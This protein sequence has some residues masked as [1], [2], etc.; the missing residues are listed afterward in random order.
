MGI[1]DELRGGGGKVNLFFHARNRPKRVKCVRCVVI[2]TWTC[3]GLDWSVGFKR[4]RKERGGKRWKEGRDENRE[5]AVETYSLEEKGHP[6]SPS[7]HVG[8]VAAKK[9]TGVND[10][11]LLIALLCIRVKEA[12]CNS[13]G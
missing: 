11:A 3:V 10:P 4:A 2:D 13:G 5:P 8:H 6:G 7:R 1:Q 12:V 9:K